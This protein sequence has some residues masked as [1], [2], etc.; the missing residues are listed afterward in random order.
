MMPGLDR[1]TLLVIVLR[2]SGGDVP[3]EHRTSQHCRCLRLA[4]TADLVALV[5]NS[6]GFRPVMPVFV[7]TVISAFTLL[8]DNDFIAAGQHIVALVWQGGAQ[9][10]DLTIVTLQPFGELL[11]VIKIAV[12]GCHD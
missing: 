1:F 6:Q 9:R 10:N 11:D 8:D 7:G 2:V 4:Y 12:I 5:Y 3:T